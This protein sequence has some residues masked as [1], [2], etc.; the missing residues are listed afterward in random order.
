M[1]DLSLT[2]ALEGDPIGS[3]SVRDRNVEIQYSKAYAEDSSATRLSVAMSR[4]RGLHRGSVPDAWLWGLLPDN[5]EVLRR[6]AA[7]YDAS[8]SSPASF[9][10]TEIGLDC[11]GAVQFYRSDHGARHDRDSSVRWLNDIELEERLLDL[12][13]DTASWHGRNATGQFSLAGAQSK[14]ALRWDPNAERWGI[15]RG[16]EPSTHIFKPAIPG[17]V[18]QHINEHLCLAAARKIGLVAAKTDIASFGQEQALVVERFDR[19][20]QADGEWLRI[21]Q[22][23]LCQALGVHPGRKYER[24]N[25]PSAANAAAVIRSATGPTVARRE[26]RRFV[27]GL[28]FNWIIGGTDAHAKNYGL[29]HRG[30]QTRLAPL[31]DISSFLPYDDSKGHKI[32]LAMKVGG[33]YKVKRIG[34]KHWARLAVELDLDETWVIERC[35]E[36]A[37]A[38][39]TAFEEATSSHQEH[40]QDSSMPDQLTALVAHA[41]KDRLNSLTKNHLVAPSPQLARYALV[42]SDS[43]P[44]DDLPHSH[45]VSVRMQLLVAPPDQDKYLY[46][47][48]IIARWPTLDLEMHSAY[49]DPDFWNRVGATAV[50]ATHRWLTTAGQAG[51]T[52]NVI[53]AVVLRMA[54]LTS[55][56]RPAAPELTFDKD[57]IICEWVDP[58]DLIQRP[59][60]DLKPIGIG[61]NDRDG[62]TLH[63]FTAS[64]Q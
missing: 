47:Q 6:W 16:E 12:R 2:I 25:G 15:P 32:K 59:Q 11:A 23:D 55:G 24:E 46:Y 48:F 52:P 50:E 5:D 37:V 49:G 36:L 14:T 42:L 31:Y 13:T 45:T 10:A 58:A 43:I 19:L 26:V 35:E 17:L 20:K 22:E 51:R 29:L 33:E 64:P 30:S 56:L 3:L 62:A 4:T 44:F 60:A 39:P 18:D 34:R 7:E 38:T 28:I 1:T 61:V 40:R 53:D 54:E 63:R 21:H 9:F 57:K 8:I 27:D 41:A